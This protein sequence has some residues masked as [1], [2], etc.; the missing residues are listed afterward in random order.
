MTERARLD[1][2]AK[3]Q[4]KIAEDPAVQ[5]VIGPEEVATRTEPL[6]ETGNELR[7]SN[8]KGGQLYELNRL[9]PGLERAA[10]GVSQIRDGFAR[11]AAGAGL[12]GEGS[13]HAEE[14]ALQIADGLGQ[15]IEGGGRAVRG[16]TKIDKGAGSIEKGTGKLVEGQKTVQGLTK[17]LVGSTN[18]LARRVRTQVLKRS[19]ELTAELKSLAATNPQLAKSATKSENL[20][21][22]IARAHE[23]AQTNNK[24]ARSL[25]EDQ[26]E[27][28]KGSNELNNGTTQLHSGTSKLHDES[29]RLPEGLEEL[30]GGTLR[31]ANGINRLQGG[32]ET[33]QSHLSEGFHRSYPLQTGLRKAS[34]K[35]T[36]GAGSLTKKVERINTQSPGLFD[37]GYFVLS[38]IDGAPAAER[39][40]AGEVISLRHGGQGAAMTVISKYTFNTQGSKDLDH[41]LQHDAEGLATDANVTAGVAGGAAQLTDYD[42][43]TRQRIPW[44][45]FAITIVTLLM[46]IVIVRALLLA[47]LAVALNLATVGVAFGVIV[48]LFNVP[49]GYP[50]GGHTYVDAI[51]AVCM[52]GVVFGLSIDYAVFLLMRMKESY[53]EDGDHAAAISLG[54]EKTARVI[55]GAAAIM[56]A[57]FIA[58]AAAP[59]ATVSQ[60][61]VGLTI[62]VLLDATV[63]RIVLLP[64]LMLLFGE[65]VWWLP[66]PLER[67]LPELNLH[68]DHAKPAEGQA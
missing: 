7:T 18:T 20:S 52:F 37:S 11:A 23:E 58:F 32:T 67:I 15:A 41:R 39:E 27:L 64:A 10:H 65:R 30:Q 4:K 38:S 17:G 26:Q 9:G 53:D 28:V 29:T 48:L 12:L 66:K 34:V 54:L 24:N 51:G 47:I 36:R 16:I 46:M 22:F 8:Q 59:I 44:V 63:V 5:A 60:L 33:L 49:A 6:K 3:W 50:L 40:Q 56:M 57:V 13:G 2:L 45:V 25:N 1:Q 62:A 68:G 55:T 14:G 31:L 19:N 61:G 35:V 21:A 42:Q 43:I